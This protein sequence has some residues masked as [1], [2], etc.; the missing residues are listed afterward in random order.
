LAW[1]GLIPASLLLLFAF[2]VPLTQR[3]VFVVTAIPAALFLI[4]YSF[5]YV[6][7]HTSFS[8]DSFGYL[9]PVLL[10]SYSTFRNLG[11]PNILLAVHRTV[12]LDNLAWIQAI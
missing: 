9:Q 3:L 6:A 8:P 1:L 7:F 4:L 5:A 10:G 11:Y 2:G 12:G